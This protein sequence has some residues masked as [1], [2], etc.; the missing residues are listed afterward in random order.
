MD[1]LDRI[2]VIANDYF[3]DKQTTVSRGIKYKTGHCNNINPADEMILIAGVNEWDPQKHRRDAFDVMDYYNVW[4]KKIPGGFYKAGS[5]D[6]SI[7]ETRIGHTPTE[8]ITNFV[9]ALLKEL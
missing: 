7:T 4:F 2:L 6:E 8:A 5:H 1:I 3:K 9:Y